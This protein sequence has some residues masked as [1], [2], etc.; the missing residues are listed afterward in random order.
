MSEAVSTAQPV[1]L[2]LR[3]PE[4]VADDLGRDEAGRHIASPFMIRRLVRDKKVACTKLARGRIVFTP[5][6]VEAML[7]QLVQPAGAVESA[8]ESVVSPFSPSQRSA[9]RR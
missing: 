2:T 1:G 3:T 5:Q 4:Q 6:Q 9:A 7:A 8:P